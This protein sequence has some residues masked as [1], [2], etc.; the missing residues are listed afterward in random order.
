M[1][2]CDPTHPTRTARHHP[3]RVTAPEPAVPFGPWVR[4]G[5][6]TRARRPTSTRPPRHSYPPS[7]T[8][9]RTHRRR[10]RRRYRRRRT[11]PD[12]GETGTS[13][14]STWGWVRFTSRHRGRALFPPRVSPNPRT[15]RPYDFHVDGGRRTD[16]AGSTCTTRGPGTGMV[17]TPSAESVPPGTPLKPVTSTGH[18]TTEKTP[19]S[20]VP[21]L[22]PSTSLP[23]AGSGSPS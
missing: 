9:P 11:G 1:R 10:H 4:R 20:S 12:E 15:L 8:R 19:S 21:V 16:A 23:V 2:V 5:A 14:D 18:G 22:E 3:R 7:R 17:Q 13:D 6:V